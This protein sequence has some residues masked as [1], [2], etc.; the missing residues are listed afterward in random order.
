MATSIKIDGNIYKVGGHLY[1]RNE[2]GQDMYGEIVG[3]HDDR[4]RGRA[5]LAIKRDEWPRE[6]WI[7]LDDYIRSRY[8]PPSK[9]WERK[10]TERKRA[11]RNTDPQ[12]NQMAY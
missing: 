2:Y 4:P 1:Y 8:F 6:E 3:V 9:A 7:C 5:L 10:E 11:E 12:P